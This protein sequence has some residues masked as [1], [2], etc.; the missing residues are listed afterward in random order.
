[1]AKPTGRKTTERGKPA[2][3][4]VNFLSLRNRR[5]NQNNGIMKRDRPWVKL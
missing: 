1:L 5:K 4:R 3:M 2:A